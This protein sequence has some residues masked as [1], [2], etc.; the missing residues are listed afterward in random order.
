MR[1]ERSASPM[2][3]NIG[4]LR[5]TLPEGSR[6]ILQNGNAVQ[7]FFYRA[8]NGIR[9]FGPKVLL[10]GAGLYGDYK[11]GQYSNTIANKFGKLKSIFSS[12]RSNYTRSHA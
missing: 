1:S 6:L 11:L 5:D 9:K 4:Y 12:Q 8:L 10:G 2:P 7:P 3:D